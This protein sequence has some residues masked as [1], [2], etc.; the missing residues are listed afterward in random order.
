[1]APWR[2]VAADDPSSSGEMTVDFLVAIIDRVAHPVFVKDRRFRFVLVNRALCEMVGYT[3]DAMIGKSDYDFFPREQADFFHKMDVE[4]FGSGATVRVEEEAIT[5][6]DGRLHILATTKVPYLDAAGTPTHLVGIIHDITEIKEAHVALQRINEELELRVAQRTAELAE[7]Q[8]EL[9]R[10]ERLAVLGQLSGGLAHQLRNPLGAIQN[11]VAMLR[12]DSDAETT[13]QALA[14]IDEEVRRADRTIRDLLDY[15]SIRPP[16]IDA[17]QMTSLVEQAI[18]LEHPPEG[19]D[20]RTDVDT[21]AVA[22]ADPSQL[23]AALGNVIRNAI[24]AV[25]E[26]DP[27]IVSIRVERRGERIEL[28]VADNGPGVAASARERLFEPLVTT[29]PLGVGLGLSIARN[30]IDNQGGS[31][32]Y[33]S[34]ELGG[35]AFVIDLPAAPADSCPPEAV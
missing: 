16:N 13:H 7:A 26:R 14:V 6:R 34:S 8:L 35:A 18:D 33:E 4:V 15:A 21:C 9:L 28:E 3:G 5:D 24:E 27:A 1:V 31:I 20:I 32:R 23:L 30:L 2:E 10:K 19:V 11:A 22:L 17:V 29:K 12:R 25:A